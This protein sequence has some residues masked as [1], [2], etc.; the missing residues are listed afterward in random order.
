MVSNGVLIDSEVDS[1]STATACIPVEW[2][3]EQLYERISQWLQTVNEFASPEFGAH[4]LDVR[5]NDI[6][7]P[8]AMVFD[9]AN[10]DDE[11]SSMQVTFMP[12]A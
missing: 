10:G 5:F 1:S 11:E 12:T 9:L 3:V 6:G 7:V 8:T 2:T 4:T